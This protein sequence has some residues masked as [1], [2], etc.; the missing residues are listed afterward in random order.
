MLR[1]HSNNHKIDTAFVAALFVL[2]TMTA[3]LLVLIGARQYRITA[4]VMNDN[5]E[6]RT[7]SSYL[8]EKIRQND[9]PSGTFVVDFA[10]G[11]AL[12]LKNATDSSYTTYIYYYD[13]YLRELFV[14]ENSVYTPDSGQKIIACSAFDLTVVQPG[15]ILASVTDTNNILHEIYLY[16]HV[17]SGR[18]YS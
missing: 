13:G 2:F 6:N 9:S 5:Y 11:H 1:L 3:C 7:V 15:L 14:G 17:T 18:N 8:N 12:A 16:T 4:Q 10:G